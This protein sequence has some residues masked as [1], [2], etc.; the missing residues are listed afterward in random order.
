VTKF[1][2]PAPRIKSIRCCFV[3]AV[4]LT[5]GSGRGWPQSAGA[6]LRGFWMAE[7]KADASLERAH[8]IVDPPDGKIP[9]RPEAARQQ[10]QNF[11]NL[12]TADPDKRCFQPGLPRAAYLPSPFQIF[13]NDRAVYI[14]YQDAHSY[15]IIY[16]NGSPHNEGLGYAMGD[17]RGQWDGNTLVADVSSF[18]DT[19]WLDAAGDY[20]SDELHVVERYTRMDPDT[21]KYEATIEDP[22]VFTRPWKIRMPLHLQK[23]I[24]ILEDECEEGDNGRRH[25]V[26]LFKEAR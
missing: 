10:K 20:H 13:Q 11:E 12:A 15:R 17:S 1:I 26:T 18:S 3:L 5:A 19:T 6:D 14:V 23:G 8:V 7:N 24:Q 2:F 9:Y 16:L 25:H 22:K 4:L 21:L